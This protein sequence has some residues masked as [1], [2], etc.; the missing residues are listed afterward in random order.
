MQ[1]RLYVDQ[2][3]IE[4]GDNFKKLVKKVFLRA[5]RKKATGSDEIFSEALK[6]APTKA[7]DLLTSI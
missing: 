4:T 3:R 1:G 7:A 5:P 6:C 2:I